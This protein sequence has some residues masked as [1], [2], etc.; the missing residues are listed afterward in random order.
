MTSG[1]SDCTNRIG[2]VGIEA[3]GQQIDRRI[4]RVLLQQRPASRTVVS[5]CR[6]A[7]K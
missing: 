7:M 6:L 5:A 2:F 4:E 3:K 1:T